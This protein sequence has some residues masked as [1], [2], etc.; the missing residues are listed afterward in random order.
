MAPSDGDTS[1][2]RSLKPRTPARLQSIWTRQAVSSNRAP[3]VIRPPP[4]LN[5]V[6]SFFASVRNG[7][8]RAAKHGS[9]THTRQKR[10]ADE[11][12][13]GRWRGPELLAVAVGTRGVGSLGHGARAPR[14]Q[15][16]RGVLGDRDVRRGETERR[17]PPST[18]SPVVG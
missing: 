16:H 10:P 15:N 13:G 18:R 6:R 8:G 2:K 11:C 1:R 17:R 4:R 5:I 9:F 3:Y 7:T 14:R 12:A